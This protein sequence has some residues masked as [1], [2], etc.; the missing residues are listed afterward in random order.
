[1]LHNLMV[2]EAVIDASVAGKW[3]LRDETASE[4]ANWLRVD[5]ENGRL[6]LVTPDF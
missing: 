5:L 6:T 1:M 2:I 3:Y 4:Q